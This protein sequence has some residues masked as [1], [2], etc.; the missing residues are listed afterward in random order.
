MDSQ[1]P[2]EF[3]VAVE[4]FIGCEGCTVS[5]E[6]VGVVQGMGIDDSVGRRLRLTVTSEMLGGTALK[7]SYFCIEGEESRAHDNVLEGE[8]L[9]YRTILL[10]R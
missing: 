1:K 10:P 6:K 5:V 3:L 9:E 7:V 4:G 8:V 2:V